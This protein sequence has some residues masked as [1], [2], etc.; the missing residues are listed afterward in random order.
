MLN[1]LQIVASAYGDK[2][3]V[4]VIPS[5]HASTDGNTIRTVI[6]EENPEA[7]W[8]FLKHESAHIRYTDPKLF[9]EKYI[10]DIF[11]KHTKLIA[12]GVTFD[13]FFS[14]VNALEDNRIEY[15]LSREYKGAFKTFDAMNSY[16]IKEGLWK[17]G[18]VSNLPEATF[19]FLG[20]YAAGKIG[21]LNYPSCED[22]SLSCENVLN[23][24]A[25]IEQVMF[26]KQIALESVKSDSTMDVVNL[27]FKCL[28]FLV[29]QLSQEKSE[30]GKPDENSNG[31]PDEKSNGKP[32]KNSNGQSE[33]T[34]DFNCNLKVVDKGDLISDAL[35]SSKTKTQ[36]SNDLHEKPTAF[37]SFNEE[38]KDRFSK[39]VAI[40][41]PLRNKIKHMLKARSRTSVIKS[42][43]GRKIDKRH[44]AKVKV[45]KTNVFIKKT[46]GVNSNTAVY[47]TTDISGSMKTPMGNE[48]TRLDASLQALSALI[49]SISHYKDCDY[50]L[51]T[52]NS[53]T[54][55]IKAFG[56]NDNNVSGVIDRVKAHSSTYISNSLVYGAKSFASV[57]GK[58]NRNVMIVIT[59]GTPSDHD[60]AKEII[61]NL[62]SSNVDVFAFGVDLKSDAERKMREMFTTNFINLS[63]PKLLQQEIVK[64]AE[65]IM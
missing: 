25:T 34:I 14:I 59:D 11:N 1:S 27:A 3:G 60:E 4:N 26:L 15:K 51:T 18:L 47:I 61:K 56:G 19:Q 44:L 54:Q 23:H 36:I 35:N 32:D 9:E 45:G 24:F 30:N 42:N 50:A 37:S 29:E 5:N 6:D 12:N 65:I 40:S 43:R 62:K 39:G 58:Y 17:V 8:G 31:K 49:T 13:N 63:D 53:S 41:G 20:Y 33:K 57:R 64:V 38:A 16:L 2:L 46:D 48:C 7:T 21:G 28:Y 52:F 22:L 55:V 10:V